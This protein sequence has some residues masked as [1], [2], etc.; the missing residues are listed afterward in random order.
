MSETKMDGQSE[1]TVNETE[2]YQPTP[3][4][5]MREKVAGELVAEWERWP[6]FRNDQLMVAYR[7]VWLVNNPGPP[8]F[9]LD[10]WEKDMILKMHK[11]GLSMGQL[12]FVFNRSTST[13]YDLLAKGKLNEN[14]S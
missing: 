5:A 13:V 12:A 7:M 14:E 1:L 10:D 4:E 2:E 3:E 8:P 6:D 11:V 9:H